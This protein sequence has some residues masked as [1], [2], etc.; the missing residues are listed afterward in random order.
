[1]Y[2]TFL[3]ATRKIRKAAIEEI[4]ERSKHILEGIDEQEIK[5]LLEIEDICRQ[6]LIKAIVSGDYND[7]V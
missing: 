3:K 7:I 6:H 2:R 5:N 4:D 1:M